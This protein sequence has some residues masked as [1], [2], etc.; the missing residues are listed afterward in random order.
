MGEDEP[1]YGGKRLWHLSKRHVLRIGWKEH[2]R[3][4]SEEARLQSAFAS[5]HDEALPFA[6]ERRER[7]GD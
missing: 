3:P 4:K 5:R 1:H 2:E 7:E 6:N